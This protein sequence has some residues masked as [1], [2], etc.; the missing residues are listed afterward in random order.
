[1][2]RTVEIGSIEF[3]R[4]GGIVIMNMY[5]IVAKVSGTYAFSCTAC[6]PAA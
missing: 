6:W 4:V 3:C 1:M 2:L 5:N